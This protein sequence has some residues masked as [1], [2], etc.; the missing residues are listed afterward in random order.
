MVGDGANQAVKRHA[1]ERSAMT[2]C[3]V[4]R[5]KCVRARV[6]MEHLLGTEQV[7]SISRRVAK[8]ES[9]TAKLVVAI[10]DEFQITNSQGVSRRRVKA[11][12]LRLKT[13]AI[14]A[15]DEPRTNAPALK[16]VDNGEPNADW[17]KKL[18]RHRRR[19]ASVAS[20]LDSVF[21][22]LADCDPDLWERRAYLM[23]I[24][25]VYD[26]LASSEQDLSDDSLLQLANTLAQ[27][28]RIPF[29]GSKRKGADGNGAADYGDSNDG[30]VS[31]Q[32][33]K[34][35]RNVYGTELKDV[36]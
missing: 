7:Q 14:T 1:A 29:R 15:T 6:S 35:I 17:Q 36:D 26:R 12:L 32:F 24:G 11:M 19:Q 34:L 9:I 10:D 21:G 20:I 33:V 28:R 8:A 16:R 2:P 23:V 22:R 31:N 27:Q 25:M 3:E 5:P 13:K 18:G 30:R 4:A